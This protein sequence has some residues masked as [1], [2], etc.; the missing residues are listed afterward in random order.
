MRLDFNV[1]W[2]EDQPGNIDGFKDNLRIKILKEGFKLQVIQ[3]LS[4]EDAEKHLS[5]DVFVDNID[6]VLV[7]YDLGNKM[8]GDD[9]IRKIRNK[10]P[11][12]DIIFYSAKSST[13]LRKMM[14]EKGI[15]GVF[16]ASREELADKLSGVFDALVKKVLDIDHSRG[17]VMGVTSDIDQMIN[18][19]LLKLEAELGND[20]KD[21]LQKY[22]TENIGKRMKSLTDVQNK[23]SDGMTMAEILK[24]R[25]AIPAAD[26]L[27]I[28][29]K[30]LS[31]H[32][33]SS[34][35]DIKRSISKY[36]TDI[37]QKR[38][39]LAHSR[40][41]VKNNIRRLKSS[42]DV[43]ITS[44]Y[45]RDLRIELIGHRENFEELAIIVGLQWDEVV[46]ELDNSEQDELT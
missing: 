1:L 36:L 28:L 23:I 35:A 33:P 32:Y 24:S 27:K 9:A 6:L 45:V 21:I 39:I 4:F 26:R 19:C 12:K 7:D 30:V 14:H 38:N 20:I 31:L 15:E 17:I 3:E 29:K 8:K 22:V 13:D 37:P 16:C 5:D 11:Y 10:I 2:I 46:G 43:E 34:H 44:S 18:D 40:L 25:D 41:V 42:G